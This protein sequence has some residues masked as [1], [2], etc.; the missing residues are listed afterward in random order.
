[1]LENTELNF[2][3]VYVG[4]V[5]KTVKKGRKLSFLALVVAGDKKKS[6]V[7]YGLGK[8]PEVTDARE[9][10]SNAAKKSMIKIPLREGRTLHH[11]VV[12]KF[13]STT[14]ILRSAPAG[15]G[16]IAGG[17]VRPVC[18]LLGIED[19]V[20]KCIGSTNPH[21][22]IKATLAAL[23]LTKSPRYIAEKRDMKVGEIV[24]RREGNGSKHPKGQ[25]NQESVQ[26]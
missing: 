26:V 14:V 2:K 1:M 20:A 11:D 4:R 15:T 17:L 7:G 10:A 8:A 12:G 5:C 18:E 16:I 3:L 6:K 22:V 9:K 19:V 21:N 23:S 13:G 24:S 25:N